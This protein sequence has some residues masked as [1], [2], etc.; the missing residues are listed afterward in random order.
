MVKK[1]M[2]KD[3]KNLSDDE[4]FDLANKYLDK[5]KNHSISAMILSMLGIAQSIFL[6]LGKINYVVY[7][8]VILFFYTFAYYHLRVSKESLK[9]IDEILE[10]LNSRNEF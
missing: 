8:I 1:Q 3:M 4:L 6:I 5:N 10:E 9:K 2:I 7:L